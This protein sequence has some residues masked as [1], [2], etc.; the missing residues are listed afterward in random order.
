MCENF[1]R[2]AHRLLIAC[3]VLL[4]MHTTISAAEVRVVPGDSPV[5]IR[6]RIGDDASFVK[7]FGLMAPVEVR[8]LIFR[9]TD[10]HR[11][12]GSEEI[13][14]QQV[15]LTGSATVALSPNTPKDIEIKI[16]GIK[17]PGTYTGTIYFLEPGQGL[18]P[19][20]RVP[21]E[22]IAESAPTLAPRKGSDAVKIQLFDC[23]WSDCWI[24]RLFQPGA[25]SPTYPLMFD[26]ASL[27]EF[28]MTATV[29]A[30]GEVTH[31]SLENVLSIESQVKVPVQPVFTLPIKIGDANLF[32]DHYSGDIQ[33][34][35]AM[36]APPI[37]KIPLEV[38]VR[39]GPAWPLIILFLGII[40]GRLLKYMKD[41]GNSQADLLLSFYRLET[42]IASSPDAQLLQEMLE[43]VKTLIY[44]MKLDVAKKEITDIENRATQLDTLRGLESTLKPRESEAA[45]SSILSDIRKTRD[46][47]KNK[48]DKAAADQITQIQTAMQNLPPPSSVHA[49]MQ[50]MAVAQAKR[51]GVDA[52]R[53]VQGTAEVP[54][55]SVR[56]L[57]IVTGIDSG[58]LAEV[59]LRVLRPAAWVIL[60][61]A[62]LLLG[63]QQLYLKNATFGSDPF[64]D[65][66]SL[67]VWAMSSDVASRTLASLKP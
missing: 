52:A 55:G 14:R 2:L 17:Y 30:S 16:T 50:A 53:T 26:N 57:R 21:I 43:A 38:Y 23:S 45:I 29:N 61:V 35:M 47:I 12:G 32:P 9:S 66:F 54:P 37:Y 39:T 49:R 63:M 41:K 31:R 3:A 25:F 1:Q 65:Y 7:R 27:E 36:G 40:L 24:A 13:G 42:R 48:L 28:M 64:S 67:L 22:V 33:L 62:L 44:D 15:S 60:I 20:V 8:E 18:K 10:L 4:I 11:K 46:F 5:N 6:G 56:R 59:T 19:A 51:A 34:R 58:L